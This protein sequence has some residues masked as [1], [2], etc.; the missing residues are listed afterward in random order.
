MSFHV[1]LSSNSPQNHTYRP[2]ANTETAA[3]SSSAEPYIN[4]YTSAAATAARPSTT[5]AESSPYQTSS[6]HATTTTS[7]SSPTHV[8]AAPVAV[9]QPSYHMRRTSETPPLPQ[10][11]L[12]Q[13]SNSPNYS[14]PRTPVDTAPSSIAVPESISNSNSMASN[15]A[16]VPL[17][18]H[19]AP[20]N[21][22]KSPNASTATATAAAPSSNSS[23]GYRPLNVKDA[24]TYLDQ[25]KMKFA[26]QAKV[27]NRFLDIMK[28]FKSQA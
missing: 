25:V 24:L 27:Y 21:P 23:S 17:Q 22:V 9:D 10:L 26:D 3:T 20:S 5:T 6:F 8:A 28:E 2:L 19:S 4:S 7:T 14:R 18:S 1:S 15:N 13:S 12:L 16:A 11:P